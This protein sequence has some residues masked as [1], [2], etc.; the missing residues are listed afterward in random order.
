MQVLA[1]DP[2]FRGGVGGTGNREIRMHRLFEVCPFDA[3]PRTCGDG[4]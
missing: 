4:Y 3:V 1:A 2:L